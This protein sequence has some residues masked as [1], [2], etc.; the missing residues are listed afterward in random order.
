M[1]ETMFGRFKFIERK[2]LAV[3]LLFSA[4]ML[5]I[6]L[7]LA[8]PFWA[9]GQTRWVAFP[10]QISG[11][12]LY[13]FENEF[14]L[15]FGLFDLPIPFPALTAW[16]TA[17][18]EVVLP[19]LLVIGILTRFCALALLGMTIVIQL[20]FPDA[21]INVFDP[22]NSHGLWMA[23]AVSIIFAGP[24]MFSADY[25]VRKFGLTQFTSRVA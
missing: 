8:Q 17:L 5:M 22:R 21:F 24:G 4:F 18:G 20:V 25:L 9:S 2:S 3:G 6:R 19:I 7:L 23:Y 13:L 15:H 10:T 14:A 12:T 1:L 11:S 16:I